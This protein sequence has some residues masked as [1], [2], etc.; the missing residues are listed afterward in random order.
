MTLPVPAHITL[1]LIDR[2]EAL[3]FN[4]TLGQ[5]ERHGGVIGSLAGFEAEW[6]AADNVGKWRETA[7]RLEFKGGAQ[8]VADGEAEE[9][10]AGVVLSVHKNDSTWMG[11]MY[12]IRISPLM[13]IDS[14]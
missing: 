8:G 10:A 1:Q 9:G 3:F 5:A 13:F 12:R 6:T 14:R 7:G 2:V 4:E 11:R